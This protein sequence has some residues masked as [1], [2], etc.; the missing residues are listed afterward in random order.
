MFDGVT[1]GMPLYLERAFRTSVGSVLV[2]QDR[3][4]RQTSFPSGW[5][6]LYSFKKAYSRLTSVTHTQRQTQY[7]YL[8]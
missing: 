1:G 7:I 8:L 3:M 4:S 2:S 5:F 6:P